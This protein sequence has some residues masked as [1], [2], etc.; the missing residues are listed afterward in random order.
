VR[1]LLDENADLRLAEHLSRLGHDATSIVR[2]YPRAMQDEGVLALSVSEQRTLVTS[3][4]DFGYLVFSE[5]RPYAGAIQFRLA[6]E[7]F[8]FVRERVDYVLS[9]HSDDLDKF[10]TVERDKVRVSSP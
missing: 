8:E 1:F 9:E 7:E 2:D 3:D 10:I 5:G 4:L 6:D